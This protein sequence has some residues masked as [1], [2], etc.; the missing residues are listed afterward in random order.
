MTIGM[1][2]QSCLETILIVNLVLLNLIV[3]D[4]SEI[5]GYIPVTKSTP[6]WKR[7]MIEKKNQEKLEEYI[8]R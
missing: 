2:Y 4:V 7:D 8:V 6:I 5:P 3:S 1:I